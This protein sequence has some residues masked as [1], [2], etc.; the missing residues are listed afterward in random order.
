[1]ASRLASW[2]GLRS[3]ATRPGPG[4]WPRRC[5]QLSLPNGRPR[6][7]QVRSRRGYRQRPCAG[8]CRAPRTPK[9]PLDEGTEVLHIAHFDDAVAGVEAPPGG[10]GNTRRQSVG[11][12]RLEVLD[13]AAAEGVGLRKRGG[14]NSRNPHAAQDRRARRK[15]RT[16]HYCEYP[17]SARSL[18]S[19][20]ETG[21]VARILLN[22]LTPNW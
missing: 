11:R 19:G 6:C 18:P 5:C 2:G 7:T 17:L 22:A 13:D 4:A 14:Q 15:P 3:A 1:M 16:E 10:G 8:W 21:R 12:G 9:V 20:T